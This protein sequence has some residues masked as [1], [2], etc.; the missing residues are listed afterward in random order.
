MNLH[1]M[2]IKHHPCPVPF[3]H[4]LSPLVPLGSYS[5]LMLKMER[6]NSFA[7]PSQFELNTVSPRDL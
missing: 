4:A 1:Q 2:E 5:R 7:T 3:Q 6:C